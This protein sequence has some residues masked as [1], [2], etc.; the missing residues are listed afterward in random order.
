MFDGNE[1]ENWL[2]L[3]WGNASIGLFQDKLK[4]SNVMTFNPKDV[5]GLQ[6]QFKSN[7]LNFTMEADETTEGPAFC[8][9][10]DPDGNTIMFDQ[11]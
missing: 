10:H 7:G 4:G 5:R 6:R 11:H 2:M 9:L 8:I 1:D 3:K